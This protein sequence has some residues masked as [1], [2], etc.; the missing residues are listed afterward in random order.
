MATASVPTSFTNG[1]AADASEVNGNFTALVNFLNNNT[2]HRDGSKAMTGAFDAGSQKIVNLATGTNSNDGVNKAQLDAAIAAI[3]A[4]TLGVVEYVSTSADQD[5]TTTEAVAHT[6]TWTAVAGRLYRLTYIDHLNYG[7]FASP[8]I[9]MAI[10]QTNVSGT[11]Y[12]SVVPPN[13]TGVT[14]HSLNAFV[15]G[16]GSVT[17]VATLD[18]SDTGMSAS[19]TATSRVSYF[20]VEDIGEA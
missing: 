13:R 17:Y 9:T 2:I 14:T 1:T 5:V 20:M 12:G 10:R 8:L 3:P 6:L 4:P 7:P 19:R 18:G 11:V 15:T 16:S